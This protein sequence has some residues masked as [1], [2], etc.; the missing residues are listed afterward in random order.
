MVVDKYDERSR[1]TKSLLGTALAAKY[2]FMAR[3]HPIRKYA[4]TR[5][6]AIR[7]LRGSDPTPQSCAHPSPR[8]SEACA[9]HPRGH[10]AVCGRKESCLP[11][12]ERGVPRWNVAGDVA[13]SGAF[14]AS[15]GGASTASHGCGLVA[16]AHG[17]AESGVRSDEA[18]PPASHALPAAALCWRPSEAGSAPTPHCARL[19]PHGPDRPPQG[20][21][22]LSLAHR[23]RE[24]PCSD[25]GR[26]REHLRARRRVS[27]VSRP[28]C[29]R[30]RTRE[31]SRRS[32]RTRQSCTACWCSSRAAA[33]CRA[34]ARYCERGMVASK[35]DAPSLGARRIPLF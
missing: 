30:R 20:L 1:S 6:S 10:H 21:A 23:R 13:Q 5:A 26:S 32:L 17:A 11:R 14:A 19:S 27:H 9:L 3:C 2:K 8:A 29:P 35:R 7:G 16:R 34:A 28:A 22:C 33:P 25:A 31:V 24:A 15:R 12:D 4:N 18:P